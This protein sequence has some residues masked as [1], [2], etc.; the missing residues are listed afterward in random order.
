MLSRCSRKSF[1]TS[2]SCNGLFFSAIANRGV[3]MER[4]K[5]LVGSAERRV[6]RSMET[7]VASI[8]RT[9]SDTSRLHLMV[10]QGDDVFDAL[11]TL[12]P[13]DSKGLQSVMCIQEGYSLGAPVRRRK[14]G[15]YSVELVVLEW[16]LLPSKT[17]ARSIEGNLA[18]VLTK[19]KADERQVD[20]ITL[21]VDDSFYSCNPG[22]EEC[23]LGALH[24][25]ME[26]GHHPRVVIQR[27]ENVPK[28]RLSYPSVEY[29]SGEFLTPLNLHGLLVKKIDSG[30]I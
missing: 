18:E 21:L 3:E 16:P 1:K 10:V 20:G 9:F 7:A 25:V 5:R 24:R 13:R 29:W 4:F 15:E 8:I 14:F 12:E 11:C 2:G 28:A 26:L 30:Q 22:F 19:A 17:T 27:C 6:R 23:F